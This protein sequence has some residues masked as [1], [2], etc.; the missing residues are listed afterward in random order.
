MIIKTCPQC[1]QSFRASKNNVKHCSQA[2]YDAARTPPKVTCKQC[3]KQWQPGKGNLKR[4]F[5][6]RKCWFAWHK[7]TNHKQY[8]RIPVPCEWCGAEIYRTPYRLQKYKHQYCSHQCSSKSHS[9]KMR[10]MD[11]GLPQQA[12]FYTLAEWRN[13][14]T[15]ALTRDGYKCIVCD[16]TNDQHRAKYKGQGLHVDHIEPRRINNLNDLHNLQSL[17]AVH[18]ARKT[19]QGR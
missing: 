16:L 2:C 3:N 15:L 11:Q 19:T 18:H 5:C 8:N 4:D 14:R 12:K 10:G 7:T 13:I 17:C 6:S 1:N 9:L